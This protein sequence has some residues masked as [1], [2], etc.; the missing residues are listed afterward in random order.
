MRT[1]LS[2]ILLSLF[3]YFIPPQAFAVD[4][5]TV[6]ELL[7]RYAANQDKLSSFI[8]KTEDISYT[9]WSNKEQPNLRRMV[10]EA[11]IDGKRSHIFYHIWD[12]LPNEDVS[13]TIE[14]ASNWV[15]LW[16]GNL[17][18]LWHYRMSEEGTGSGNISR[19]EK[20]GKANIN[21][22]Y[23]GAPFMGIRY[24]NYERID[25]V[26]RQADTMSVRKEL[27]KIGS[28][29]CYVIDAETNSGTYTAWF[30]PQHGYQIAQVEI[31][32]G[33]NDHYRTTTL[34]DDESRFL[35]VKNIRFE[36]IDG[37]WIPMEA[38]IHVKSIKPH[39]GLSVII[40][41]HHKVTHMNLNPD[42]EALGS[43]VPVVPNGTIMWDMDFGIK[44]TWQERM[45][46]VV[47]HCDG[48]IKYVPKDWSILVGVDKPLPSF[49]GIEL[50]LSAEQIKDKTI[51]LCFF[52]MQQRPSRNCLRQ[53]STRAQELKAQG[54]VVMAI[55][56]SEVEQAKLNEWIEENNILFPVGMIEND[57]EKT[58]FIWGVRSLPWLILTDK[59]HIVTAEG[60][61]IAELDDKLKV[62][63]R[64]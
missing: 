41:K 46:F 47:D 60:F 48:R 43:F 61:S 29:A 30:D 31:S 34:K 52:D 21:A 39:L 56:A 45:K 12:D 50:D 28:S 5:L 11:R 63:T 26:I 37:T 13:T 38:D 3:L 53:L 35:S 6:S 18:I 33:P 1:G 64:Q 54:V 15:D 58:R 62:L 49:E 22:W 51:L 59:E 42:H 4:E 14:Q 7:D 44:Y 24:S 40:D 17:A 25:S 27:E 16:N 57:T 23:N 32:V 20:I 2:I 36:N 55:Q 8:A 19:D 9:K 10:T